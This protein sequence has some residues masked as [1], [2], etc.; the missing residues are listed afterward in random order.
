MIQASHSVIDS[1]KWYRIKAHT[2]RPIFRGVAA[3]LV[4]ESADSIPESADS[5][6]DSV[7]VSRLPVLNIFNISTP[8][9]SADSRRPTI[10]SVD[11]KSV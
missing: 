9:Q 10:A 11:C 6:T 4:V 3:E 8:I 7:I 1:D 5:T 2:H